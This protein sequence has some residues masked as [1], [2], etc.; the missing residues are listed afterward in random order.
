MNRIDF[1]HLQ[2]QL[3]EDALPKLLQKAYDTGKKIKIKTVNEERTETLNAL[4][5]AFDDESFIPHGTKKDGFA[6]QQPIFISCEANNPNGAEYLFLLDGATETVDSLQKYERIFNLFDGNTES[7]LSAAREFWKL[8]K[9]S[10]FDVHYWQQSE[11][12]KWE[13]K[14]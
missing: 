5:W 1:Y 9:N 8:C 2:K 14:A 13:Q 7:N 6:E 4:L 11:R 10:G 12:G 3:P